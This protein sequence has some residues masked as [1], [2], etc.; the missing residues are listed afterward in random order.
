MADP[1]EQ[2]IRDALASVAD[3]TA[4]SSDAEALAGLTRRLERKKAA[5]QS[6][7]SGPF[8]VAAAL[9]LLT[10]VITWSTLRDN[11]VELVIADATPPIQFGTPG[12][13]ELGQSVNVKLPM[14][15]AGDALIS[16]SDAPALNS[17]QLRLVRVDSP[18]ATPEQVF[19]TPTAGFVT[20]IEATGDTI[21][22]VVTQHVTS[23]LPLA[24]VSN[25]GGS[26]W[27]EAELP[28]PPDIPLSEAA[29]TDAAISSDRFVVLGPHGVW[30]SATGNDWEFVE[31]LDV[32]LDSPMR[33]WNQLSEVTWTG[34]DFVIAGGVVDA[35]LPDASD[36]DI[37]FWRSVDGGNWAEPVVVAVDASIRTSDGAEHIVADGNGRALSLTPTQQWED[38][39]PNADDRGTLVAV[40]DTDGGFTAEHLA[41]WILYD[42]FAFDNG[43]LAAGVREGQPTEPRFL[44]TVDGR[45]W[46]DVGPAP[47]VSSIGHA[48]GDH[49]VINGPQIESGNP[50][51]TWV[52]SVG[53]TGTPLP[54][55]TT[56]P[57][58]ENVATTQPAPPQD[59]DP[60]QG[61]TPICG[62]NMPA[63]FQVERAA[64][65]TSPSVETTLVDEDGTLVRSVELDGGEVITFRWPAPPRPLRD[66]DAVVPYFY[67]ELNDVTYETLD[68]GTE[69]YN[70]RISMF[71]AV[72]QQRLAVE[73]SLVDHNVT[74]AAASAEPGC[75]V[76]EVRY[77]DE[78]GSQSV[79]GWDLAAERDSFPIADLA[80]MVTSSE[81]VDIAPTDA[82]GCSLAENPNLSETAPVGPS[83]LSPDEALEE[84]LQTDA[85]ETF[86]SNGFHGMI[87][88]DGTRTYG[89]F[90]EIPDGG[91]SAN[92]RFVT[93]VEVSE[94]PQGWQVTNWTASGC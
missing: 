49:V 32:D 13:V 42:A 73:L 38:G 30:V 74:Q 34:D 36:H 11:T 57:G 71:D 47:A 60:V 16:S 25:D 76:I 66:L 59:Q 91:P 83:F 19:S 27:S 88:P 79:F 56:T 6:T 85:A 23:Q 80:P 64:G 15:I 63:V 51:H 41:D 37:A 43:F 67:P 82:V 48:W 94:S 2:T 1:L 8:S 58:S 70:Y 24:F 93:L 18:T 40:G 7:R 90:F 55:P 72:T 77:E 22:A 69:E 86:I 39:R 75:E 52:L 81:N 89:I 4:M 29:A 87:T 20:A 44:F 61:V 92:A 84:F 26:T 9:V 21:L 53:E 10:G 12:Q 68:D 33:T 3:N 62:E 46:T 35:E 17:T 14:A 31:V 28:A 5:T 54:T 78:T 65:S 50:N 45:S